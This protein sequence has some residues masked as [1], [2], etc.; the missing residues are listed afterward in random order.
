MISFSVIIPTRHRNDGLAQCLE[1]L[2]SIR[3]IGPGSKDFQYEVIVTDDGSQSTAQ[4]MIERR[5]AWVK[6]F[7]GPRRGPAANRNSGAMNASSEWLAFV[8]DDCIPSPGWLEAFVIAA[9]T[10]EYAVLEG[11][12]IPRGQQTGAD[13]G[14]PKNLDG[15]RLWSCNFAIKRNL[16]QGLAGFDENYPFAAMEDV[17]LHFR[18]RKQQCHIKFVAG[19]CVEHPWRPKGD[20]NYLR[21]L[22]QSLAYF[23]EK[24]PESEGMFLTAWGLKRLVRIF[25][26]ELPHNILRFRHKGSFRVLYLDLVFTFHVLSIR[27]KRRAFRAG[28]RLQNQAGSQLAS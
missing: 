6:W 14:C 9:Q 13:Q 2:E 28:H 16:F 12:T 24:H 19:A 7:P 17:D 27:A 11:K 3:S 15:G 21:G 25:V 26:V 1:G 18:I 22:A 10:G 5:F 4:A 23:I 20:I 8:D